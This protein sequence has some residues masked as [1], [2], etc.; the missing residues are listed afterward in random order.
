M[1][2]ELIA[3]TSAR[4]LQCFPRSISSDQKTSEI[5]SC[6]ASLLQ[7]P[8]NPTGLM[9]CGFWRSRSFIWKLEM[10]LSEECCTFTVFAMTCKLQWKID[11]PKFI[12]VQS[13][14]ASWSSCSYYVMNSPTQPQHGTDVLITD[15]C[16]NFNFW[17]LWRVVA[18]AIWPCSSVLGWKRSLLGW[19]RIKSTNYP[20]LSVP[21]FQNQYAQWYQATKLKPH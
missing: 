11:V 5:M 6:T 17:L 14:T 20:K 8:C 12:T 10:S 3:L 21:T 2:G 13:S 4:S 19:H 18:S 1:V 9:V 15:E 16:H 7:S